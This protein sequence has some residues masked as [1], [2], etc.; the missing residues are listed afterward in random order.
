MNDLDYDSLKHENSNMQLSPPTKQ[1]PESNHV[2]KT[3]VALS[4]ETQEG[5]T[6]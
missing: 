3:E 2:Y 4:V 1:A 5:T 6:S